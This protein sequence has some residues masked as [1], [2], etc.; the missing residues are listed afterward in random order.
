METNCIILTIRGWDGTRILGVF[1]DIESAK[2]AAIQFSKVEVKEKESNFEEEFFLDVVTV[3]KIAIGSSFT[4]SN[5][6]DSDPLSFIVRDHLY[7]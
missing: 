4:S 3:G 2:A 1:K 7:S 5:Q 6:S